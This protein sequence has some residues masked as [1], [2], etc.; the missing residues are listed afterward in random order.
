MESSLLI[1]PQTYLVIDRSKVQNKRS[2]NQ[3]ASSYN[4]V[5]TQQWNQLGNEQKSKITHRSKAL[6][7]QYHK[8]AS[9]IYYEISIIH[10]SR[11]L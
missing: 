3:I 7:Q 6:I 9:M 2:S 4:V 11:N 1:S 10:I 8:V 5:V